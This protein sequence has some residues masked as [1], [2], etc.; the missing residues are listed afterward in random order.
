MNY[1]NNEH[2]YFR[3]KKYK[4]LIIINLKKKSK[5]KAS[6]GSANKEAGTT[7]HFE[8]VSKS[9]RAVNHVTYHLKITKF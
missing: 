9:K 2:V 1:I 8:Q 6:Q 5:G 7:P 4:H 3:W